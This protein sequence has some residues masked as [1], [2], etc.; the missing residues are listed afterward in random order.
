MYKNNKVL[1]YNRY[2]AEDKN[3]KKENTQRNDNQKEVLL[4]FFTN[5]N[6]NDNDYNIIIEF[7]NENKNNDRKESKEDLNLHINM[8]IVNEK[9][10]EDKDMVI[11]IIYKTKNN[12]IFNQVNLERNNYYFYDNHKYHHGIDISVSVNINKS[13]NKTIINKQYLHF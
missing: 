12:H 9:K 1:E 5:A 7:K 4:Q 11:F 6:N 8:A 3:N 13:N 10:K 2:H